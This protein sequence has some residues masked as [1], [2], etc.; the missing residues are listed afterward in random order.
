M[1]NMTKKIKDNIKNFT[2]DWK[3]YK[4]KQMH[5]LELEATITQIKITK[6]HDITF[7]EDISL[8]LFYLDHQSIW[9]C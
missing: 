7:W 9:N 5:I 6:D 1:V 8:L 2:K 3:L 4:K